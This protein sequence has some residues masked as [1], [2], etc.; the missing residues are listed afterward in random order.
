MLRSFPTESI[1]KLVNDDL[2]SN[3]YSKCNWRCEVDGDYLCHFLFDPKCQRYGEFV[4]LDLPKR[5]EFYK[6]KLEII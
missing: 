2:K 3:N 1:I 6:C 5:R 4:E